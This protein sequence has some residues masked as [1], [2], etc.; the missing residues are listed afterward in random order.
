MI[1]RAGG[2]ASS[3]GTHPE[4]SA[5]RSRPLWKST[6]LTM[7]GEAPT[8]DSVSRDVPD[9]WLGLRAVVSGITAKIAIRSG[10]PESPMSPPGALMSFLSS[11]V[12]GENGRV[13]TAY[14]LRDC[15]RT[16]VTEILLL[17][18]G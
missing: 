8:W 15:L 11:A 5:T 9:P 4:T 14:E 10:K 7:R 3:E 6:A 16:T 17:F 2:A 13:V 12:G 18:P 1:R